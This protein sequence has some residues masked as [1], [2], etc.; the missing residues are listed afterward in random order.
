MTS[1]GRQLLTLALS[2][3]L[4]GVGIEAVLH[5]GWGLF[6]DPHGGI[7]A[8]TSVETPTPRTPRAPEKPLH[9]WAQFTLASRDRLALFLKQIGSEQ[10]AQS[11]GFTPHSG[12]FASG[13]VIDTSFP[14]GQFFIATDSGVKG[15]V[16]AVPVKPGTV[17]LSTFA[18][19][20]TV[21]LPGHPDILCTG[22]DLGY[23]RT[24][25]LLFMGGTP[26][27]L[28][29]F[30]DQTFADYSDRTLLLNLK[31]DLDAL[32]N[33]TFWN[34]HEVITYWA[35]ILE[36]NVLPPGMVHS[37]VHR[38]VDSLELKV[39]FD[40]QSAS[41]NFTAVVPA[42][43]APAV[44][45]PRPTL[46]RECFA[47]FD[48]V[49]T[50]A[51]QRTAT[52]RAFFDDVMAKYPGQLPGTVEEKKASVQAI[53]DALPLALGDATTLG[54]AR[55]DSLLT[56]FAVNQYA[57][58]KNLLGD[59]AQFRKNL[60]KD[61]DLYDGQVPLLQSTY[62]DGQYHVIRLKAT[63]V[64]WYMDFIQ[65]ENKI[66]VTFAHDDAHRVVRL[67]GAQK[68]TAEE[69]PNL[70]AYCTMPELN[71]Y[72]QSIPAQI[73]FPDAIRQAAAQHAHAGPVSL[74]IRTTDRKFIF[75]ATFPAAFLA[76]ALKLIP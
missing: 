63:G 33:N 1:Q 20:S 35:R 10:S 22:T 64:D 29:Q 15:P 58:P 7:A 42:V 19:L 40:G 76:P 70:A 39:H 25:H 55:E 65:Q 28:L 14:S 48:V 46:P 27:T 37:M 50:S 2:L 66:F 69:T 26:E 74:E 41:A 56:F 53:L 73:G 5:D 52:V 61:F 12:P 31:A 21:P 45:F 67:A 71:N 36:P 72:I 23:R 32:R 57:Q 11:I 6:G 4:L 59:I 44:H 24:G 9:V 16:F 3:L 38:E 17:P 13:D 51:Q 60:A 49:S 75:N 43:R 68:T 54:I 30:N 34:C 8:G 18:D 47:R 62:D